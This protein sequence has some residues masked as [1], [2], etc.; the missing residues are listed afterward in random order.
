MDLNPSRESAGFPAASGLER[1]HRAKKR[2]SMLEHVGPISQLRSAAIGFFF[3]SN[4]VNLVIGFALL[5]LVVL[6]VQELGGS[7]RQ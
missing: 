5:V 4:A 3:L 1:G 6:L 7:R 2:G